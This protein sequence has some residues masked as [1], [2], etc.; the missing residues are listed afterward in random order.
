MP[1]SQ[2]LAVLQPNRD[3][4]FQAGHRIMAGKN[5]TENFFAGKCL[6]R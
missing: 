5:D 2:R 4:G 6:N 1:V 3:N